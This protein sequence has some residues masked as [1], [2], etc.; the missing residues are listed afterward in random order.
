LLGRRLIE[1]E[2]RAA[3]EQE[4]NR[5]QPQVAMAAL[6][7]FAT[8]FGQAPAAPAPAPAPAPVAESDSEDDSN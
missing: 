1:E 2:K 6:D 7:T 8:M 3:A 4:R 5:L